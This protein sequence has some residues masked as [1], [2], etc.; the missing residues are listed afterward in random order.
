MA[1][2]LRW[3]FPILLISC[4]LLP[5]CGKKAST[6]GGGARGG[7]NILRYD[8]NSPIGSL[9]P[10]R[11]TSSSEDCICPLLYSYLFVPNGEG[12]F[13]PDLAL[14][15]DYGGENRTWRIRIRKD[16]FFHDGRP[17][18]SEDVMH[19]L[20]NFIE[21]VRPVLAPLVERMFAPSPD[22]LDIVL[23]KDD[24]DFPEKIW[25]AEIVPRQTNG[26]IDFYN[27]PIGSGPFKFGY[28]RGA[29]EV[30]L[31]AN[32]KYYC[33]RPS[34]DAI[35]FYYLADKDRSWARLLAGKTDIAQEIYPKDYEMI[36][37]YRDKFQFNEHVLDYFTILLYNTTDPLFSDPRIRMALACA[38]DREHIV[39]KI[40]R[41]FGV[42]ASGP[43]GVNSVY[44]NPEVKPIPYDPQKAIEL[45][46]EAGWS[47]DGELGCLAR[48]GVCFEF[49][50]LVF[51]GV[52]QSKSIAEYIQL[53]LNE[54]GVRV[55]ARTSPYAELVPKYL[56]N[57][58]FQAVLTEAIGSHP[59]PE[60]LGWEWRPDSHGAPPLGCFRSPEIT[61]LL[62]MALEE[63][64]PIKKKELLY[65]IDEL[66]TQLQPGTFLFH[67]VALDA[68]SRRISLPYPISLD[69]SGIYSLKY[70]TLD[71]SYATLD[72]SRAS[73]LLRDNYSSREN[74]FLP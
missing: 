29:D 60:L 52:H 37:K 19:S 9:D 59:C 5:S 49:T 13:E 50:L 69:M 56:K 55:H 66:I 17:V 70:A 51:E 41:G 35:R 39:K 6:S 15:W 14:T 40:L 31:V 63:T 26:G 36:R 25:H 2:N 43:M 7:E 4:L 28:R 3:I 12:R 45:F 58:D 64:Q 8:V 16:A 38:I 71:S 10:T 62:N 73:A 24:P 44:H 20:L 46:R 23:T 42:V 74:G 53:C 11:G 32:P 22:E 34:F 30:G 47:Y 67:R 72:S 1:G 18:A 68:I 54:I 33:G 61:R 57:K 48:N 21:N 27:R 65:K